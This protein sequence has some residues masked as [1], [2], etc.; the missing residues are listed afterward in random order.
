[1]ETKGE[2]VSGSAKRRLSSLTTNQT[3][4]QELKRPR[5]TAM[6]AT[7]VPEAKDTDK[8][9]SQRLFGGILDTLSQRDNPT[10]L[11]KRKEIER[12]QGDRWKAAQDE[13]KKSQL[14]ELERLKAQRIAGLADWDKARVCDRCQ[15]S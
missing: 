4:S 9:R 14:R 15:V 6:L 7:R 12:R 1:M 11:Q 5:S 2:A 13:V 3:S 8:E 10:T